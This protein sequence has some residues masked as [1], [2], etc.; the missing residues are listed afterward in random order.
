MPLS[1]FKLERYFA[2]YE[3][4]VKYLLSASD[5]ESLPMAELLDMASPESLEL[6]Q[7]LKLGYTELAGH[8][9]LLAEIAR[10]YRDIRPENIITA[11]PEEA[12]FI[13]MH[14]LLA[15]GDEVVAVSPAYQ[16]LHE[17]ARATGCRLIS[18][19]FRPGADGWQL[20]L[21]DLQR[22]LTP[23]TRLLILNFPHNPTGFLPD[24]ADFD[25]ILE[26]ARAHGV[27]VFSDEMYRLL[28]SDPAERLPS[29]CD[30]YEKGIALSGL[31][32]SFALP[33]LR[34]G[35]LASQMPGLGGAL[36]GLQRLHHHLLL[37]PLR[38]PGH[39]RPA[40][41]GA[42]H[43]SAITPSSPPTR[44][45]PGS[46]SMPTRS[47]SPGYPPGAARSPSRSG[48]APALWSSFARTS[49]MPAA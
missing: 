38:N 39:H 17:I 47:V 22:S 49:W 25:A 41:Q 48:W 16:S 32:K 35:W 11:A 40:K 4:K 13:A 14:T 37:R 28:E 12:I 27:V 45:S 7:S 44:P 36:A 1:P 21:N 18:W 24:R 30:V 5:C 29:I 26:L 46:F 9:L 8:P 3:F 10:L 20:D 6:W 33:G 15:P 34:L 43:Y 42:H 31:S 2:Q 19:Q 23:R